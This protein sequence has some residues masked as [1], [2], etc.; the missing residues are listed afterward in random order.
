MC[1]E[2]IEPKKGRLGPQKWPAG[3]EKIKVIAIT[4]QISMS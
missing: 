2:N 3:L 1:T 4:P